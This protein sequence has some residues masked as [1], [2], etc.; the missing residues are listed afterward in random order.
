[1]RWHDATALAKRVAVGAGCLVAL[2]LCAQPARG[3]FDAREC[4]LQANI[5]GLWSLPGNSEYDLGSTTFNTITASNF[6]VN[7]TVMFYDSTA[8]TSV[9]YTISLDG[10]QFG[11]A[12]RMVPAVFPAVHQFRVFIPNVAAGVHTLAVH[13]KNLSPSPVNYFLTWISPLLIDA[14]ETQ[15]ARSVS[16]RSTSGTAWTQLGAFTIS[17]PAG[18]MVYLDSYAEVAAG[19]S[20]DPLEYQ[21]LRNGTQ[22]AHFTSA[23]PA[24]FPDSFEASFFDVNPDPNSNLYQFQVRSSNGSPTTFGTSTLHTETLPQV[25][26][27]DGSAANISIPADAVY[28][29]IASSGWIPLMSSSLGPY[30]TSGHGAAVVTANE[31]YQG[32]GLLQLMLRLRNTPSLPQVEVGIC[33]APGNAGTLNLLPD[34]SDWETLGLQANSFYKL[35]LQAV[36]NCT[37]S[38]ARNFPEIRFQVLAVPDSAGV[39]ADNNCKL[40]DNDCCSQHPACIT[41]QCNPNPSIPR[42]THADVNLCTFPPAP[43]PTA[44]SFYTVTPCRAFDSRNPP[45]APLAFNSPT[46]IKVG[47]LCGIPSSAK[48]VVFNVTVVNP[49]ADASVQMYPGDEPP[50]PGTNVNSTP[51]GGVRAA[52]AVI[53]LATNGTGVVT[54]L[55]TASVSGQTDLA[56]DVSGYFQ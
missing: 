9:L 30:G 7:A 14:S 40:S 41:Y 52:L 45:N 38:P 43:E 25:T 31:S 18:K 39:H 26:L 6:V 21:L 32:S 10:L 42:N 4:I 46:Q 56:L 2:T 34:M 20:G 8:G 13:A 51:A 35:D 3:D 19:H 17:P 27:F 33:Y 29:T 1:M 16:G 23:V 50:P 49:S 48:S 28:H 47:G 53:E 22:I 11:G 44:F 5:D 36:G 15:Q 55:P 24:F 37:G 54:V 12:K